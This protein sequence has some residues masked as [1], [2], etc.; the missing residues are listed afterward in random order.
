MIKKWGN[1]FDRWGKPL[2]LGWWPHELIW[3]DAAL[4][5]PSSEYR[6]A[7]RDIGDLTGRGIR[8]VEQ[9]AHSIVVARRK[10]AAKEEARQ[11]LVAER[12]Q[13]VTGPARPLTM[14]DLPPSTIR[15]PTKAQLMGGR[16]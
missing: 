15:R 1:S 10:E 8:A 14:A 12:C 16:A 11:V 5:L 2:I 6:A 9:K 13:P 4:C 7:L 3:I